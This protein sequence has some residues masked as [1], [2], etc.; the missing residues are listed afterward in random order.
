MPTVP[1]PPRFA[2]WLLRRLHPDE[3]REEVQG[4][5]AELYA[6][7]LERH[8]RRRADLRYGLAVLSV[9]P[10]FVRRRS[11]RDAFP[12]PPI[13]QAAMLQ[14]NLLLAF[15]NAK[16]FK[17]TFLINLAG[18]STGLACALL[19]GLW[20]A[21]EL[22]MDRFHENG[23]RL[24]QV[25]Q[26]IHLGDGSVLTE[27][28]TPGQLGP[29][30]RDELPGVEAV[31]QTTEGG[32]G[33]LAANDTRTKAKGLYVTPNF[34]RFFSYPLLQG[35]PDQVLLGKRSVVLSDE[36]ARKLFGTTQGVTGKT[37]VWDQPEYSGPYT[38]AGIFRKMSRHSSEQFDLLLPF[39]LYADAR[40]GDMQN[41]GSSNP[42]T[43]LLL[44]PGTDAAALSSQVTEFLRRKYEAAK[45][46]QYLS[47]VGYLFLKRFSDKYL[48]NRYE[49]GVQAGGRIAYVKL[50]S[51]IG[52]FILVIAAINFTNLSTARASTRL[53]EIG[54]KKAIGADRR[55]LVVQ[56]LSESVL[57]AFAAGLLAAGL[58]AG[59]L[60]R[61]NEITGKRLDLS[62]TPQGLLWVLALTLGTGLLAGSYP[63]LYLSGF[64]PVQVLKG[65]L[66]PSA[67]EAWTRKG[68]VVFQFT[69][70]IILVVSVLVVHRQIGY[71]QAKNLGYNKNNVVYFTGEGKLRGNLDPFL[72]AVRNLPGVV[73]ASGM[74]GNLTGAHSS[75]GAFDWPGKGADQQV[76]FGIFYVNYD[77]LETLAIPLA[78][79]RP[80]SRAFP[81]D[82]TSA[83][84]FNQAAIDAMGLEDPVGKT[85]GFFGK[86]RQI[87]GV[88]KNFHFESLYEEVKPVCFVYRPRWADRVVVKLAAGREREALGRLEAL[89]RQFNEGLPLEYTFLDQDYRVLYAAEARVAVLSRYFAG[90]AGLISGLGL[91]GLA[92][93]TVERRTREIGIRKVLGASV[94]SL[95]AL[96]SRDFLRLVGIALCIACPVAWYAMRTWLDGFAY[97]V[98]LSW[99]VFALT[100][101]LAVGVALLTVSFQSTRAA[102]RNPVKSL[103]TE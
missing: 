75:A 31:A 90:I 22:R 66:A 9:L 32:K 82:S 74:G 34:L 8:G 54:V 92:A 28:S 2:A 50:F 89:Y 83:I 72:A 101:L 79:G 64:R 49:G 16:R 41:W 71:I 80:L 11:K 36:L 85:V 5:L 51:A 59:L 44:K 35:N 63:A 38:V 77:L 45:G 70:S 6:G 62:P 97:R 13:F 81:T 1:Q 65:R 99:E 102:L 39:G 48:Y 23:P 47:S 61:F 53:K 91:F 37:V 27:E 100:G 40:A 14:H 4:D 21:D 18:L 57:L 93:F 25:I 78:S 58:V 56:F 10:P 26:H 69:V 33:I 88:T 103:R 19:I 15:R 42:K 98:A 67:G 43:Y 84:L 60:P 7:W 46:T 30:L 24:Y 12:Q 87:V 3:T 94:G 20:V 52:L 55:A 86:D 96:L 29:A 76:N 17:V 73:H 95:V 68:L